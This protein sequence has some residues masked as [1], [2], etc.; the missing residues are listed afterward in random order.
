MNKRKYIKN[1]LLKIGIGIILFTVTILSQ[2][3]VTA[4]N[5]SD[6]DSSKIEIK[7]ATILLDS[8]LTFKKD[9]STL[10]KK[11]IQPFK[12]KENRNRRQLDS[13][14]HFMLRMVNKGELKIDSSTVD[15][16]MLQLDTITSLNQLNKQDIDSII[17]KN[18]LYKK[19]SK[20]VI[21]SLRMQMGAIEEVVENNNK[22]ENAKKQQQQNINKNYLQQLKEIQYASSVQLR[23]KDSFNQRD[24]L[25]YFDVKLKPRINIIGWYETKNKD[26]YLNY[27]YHYLSAINLNGYELTSGGKMGN[28]KTISEF[29]K[30]GGIIEYATQKNCPV[31]LTVFSKNSGIISRFLNDSVAQ[32][33]LVDELNSLINKDNL[34]GINIYFE[35]IRNTNRNAFAG[36]VTKLR[37]NLNKD[38]VQLNLSIPAIKNNH[39]LSKINAYDFSALNP[40][41]DYYIVLTDELT[42]LENN[43]ALTYS[44]LYNS[45]SYGQRTIESTVNF[46]SNGKI[47]L[48]KLI[49]TL[50]YMGIEWPVNDSLGT[51]TSNMAVQT[52]KYNAIVDKYK[53]TQVAKRL[54]N[55]G[56]DTIQVAAYLNVSYLDSTPT[57]ILNRKQVWFEDSNSLFHKYN[58]I[59]NNNLG[60]V[61]IRGLGYDNGYSE[62]WDVLGTTLVKLDTIFYTVETPQ[63]KCSCKYDSIED[64]SNKLKLSNWKALWGNFMNYK[65]ANN[66]STFW[67]IF[68]N[69]YQKAKEANLEY[70]NTPAIPNDKVLANKDVCV[71]LLIRWYIY[72]YILF[73]IAVFFWVVARLIIMRRNYLERHNPGINKNSFIK[74]APMFFTLAGLFFLLL[75]VYFEP[76]F[77]SIGAGNQGDSDFWFFVL[78]VIV[79]LILGVL[80]IFWRMRDKNKYKNKNQP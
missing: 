59:L 55:G 1:S 61:S 31:H 73:G 11:I 41:V 68:R 54:V 17:D 52:L 36:F 25:N 26:E 7:P 14:Y 21:D 16:I 32:Q 22:K 43:K 65:K 63:E 62:L 69:D 5:K 39:S 15:E 57:G 60:G 24:N 74:I 48:S 13:I 23:L 4:Q 70:F 75:G 6:S 66:D 77:D 42:S 10:L 40:M 47:P 27:N 46:Y 58:W 34:K 51:V 35:G 50:S 44:P 2:N 28:P 80:L 19:A 49:P 18:N 30:P 78:A 76:K 72:A 8:T 71:N 37:Q 20:K 9:N 38:S 45:D 67:V 33:T 3:V 79:G 29:E 64:L 53:N 56:F 12:F